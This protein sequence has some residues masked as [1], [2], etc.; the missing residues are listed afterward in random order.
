MSVYSV[1]K[2]YGIAYNNSNLRCSE[3]GVFAESTLFIRERLFGAIGKV[4][5][6]E[7]P[8]R[9]DAAPTC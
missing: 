4:C 8:R 7:S 1:D 3:F 9:F 2:R 6:T 5:F